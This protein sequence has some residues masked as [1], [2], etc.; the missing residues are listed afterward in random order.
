MAWVRGL[1]KQQRRMKQVLYG[2]VTFSLDRREWVKRRLALI[3]SKKEIADLDYYGY[4]YN[5]K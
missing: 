3:R 1:G 4:R 5:S 2:F